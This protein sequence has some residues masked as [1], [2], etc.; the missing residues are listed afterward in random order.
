VLAIHV[1]R[2][3]PVTTDLAMAQV[4]G[5]GMAADRAQLERELGAESLR[6]KQ[7]VL[8]A[9]LPPENVRAETA[10]GS[11]SHQIIETAQRDN[12]DLIIIGNRRGPRA[13]TMLGTVARRV[14]RHA[15]CPVLTVTM[16]LDEIVD[17]EVDELLPG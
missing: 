17:D 11:P 15:P 3:V 12:S 8:E 14:L 10:L 9:G 4:G 13:H 6:W 1:L 16:S 5:A 2:A 7:S